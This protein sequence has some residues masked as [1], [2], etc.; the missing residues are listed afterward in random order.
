MRI[1]FF[2]KNNGL[3]K[4][5]NGTDMYVKKIKLGSIFL[6]SIY[7]DVLVI[8]GNLE[9]L[10]EEIKSDWTNQFDTKDIGHLQYCLGI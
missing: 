7:V 5:S 1:F 2:F 6:V 4:S 3:N 10:I 8:T 9:L